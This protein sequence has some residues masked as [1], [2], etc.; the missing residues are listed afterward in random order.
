MPSRY[1]RLARNVGATGFAPPSAEHNGAARS[2]K[3]EKGVVLDTQGENWYEKNQAAYWDQWP[4][5]VVGFD[6]LAAKPVLSVETVIQET[7]E[8]V[9]V[10][11]IHVAT[12]PAPEPKP[13]VVD[14]LGELSNK[15]VADIAAGLGINT[16]NESK[17]SLVRKI[18][19]ARAAAPADTK[20]E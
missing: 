13:L 18:R 19:A 4:D 3:L 14:N 11:T 1:Y 2:F 8:P 7:A 12:E 10:A 20:A 9:A 17:S 15:E 16:V 6:V 5:L